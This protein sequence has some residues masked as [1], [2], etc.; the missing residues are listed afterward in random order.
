MLTALALGLVLSL[1]ILQNTPSFKTAVSKH[2]LTFLEHE[3][4]TRI[5]VETVKLNFFTFSIYF[6]NGSLTSG[7]H[8]NYVWGFE[9]AKIHVSPL[10]LLFD[11]EI[12]LDLSFNN[13]KGQSA[14]SNNRIDI[15]DHI[16]DIFTQRSPDLKISVSSL[17]LNN[18]DLDL[19]RDKELYALHVPGSL[20]LQRAQT[21]KKDIYHWTGALDLVDAQI[22]RND[23]I[24]AQKITGPIALDKDIET[25]IWSFKPRVE[26]TS[27]PLNPNITYTLHG[28]WGASQHS[29]ELHDTS[30]QILLTST[31]VANNSVG[32]KGTVPVSF[33]HNIASQ[34]Q[35]QNAST[36]GTCDLNLMLTHSND[37]ITTTGSLF[38][39]D[40]KFGTFTLKNLGFNFN[41]QPDPTSLA[42]I[43]GSCVWDLKQA[44]GTLHLANIFPV[45]PKINDDIPAQFVLQPNDLDLSLTLDSAG[46]LGGIYRCTITNPTTEKRLSYKGALLLGKKTFGINGSTSRGKYALHASLDPHFHL[47]SWHYTVGDKDLIN[48]YHDKQNP[49]ILQGTCEWSLLRS[50]LNQSTRRLIFGSECSFA[51]TLDQSSNTLKQGT[52]KLQHGTLYIPEFHNLVHTLKTDF[53]LDLA[54]QKFDLSNLKLELSKGSATCPHATMSWNDDYTLQ[55][56][57][58]PLQINDM[59]INWKRDFYGSVYGNLL[60]N[61]LPDHDTLL[62][63]VLILK[64]ALL[65]DSFFNSAQS[66]TF[67]SPL[68]G[69]I[70]RYPFPCDLHVKLM[71]EKPIRAKTASIDAEASLNLTVMATHGKDY[72]TFPYLIGDITLEN[73]KVKIL[74]NKLTIDHGKIQFI[75]NRMHDPIIDLSAKNRINKY[76]VNL[77]VSGSLEKPSI[78]LESTPDLTEEQIIGLLLSGSEN[79]TL[80][81]DLPAMLL[82]NLDSL[83]W[84]NKKQTRTAA[85]FDTLSKTFKY[86]QITPNLNDSSGKSLMKGSLSLNVSDQLHAQIH[87]NL[88]TQHNDFSAQLEYYLTDN[89]NIKVVQDQRDKRGESGAEIEVCLKL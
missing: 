41:E 55:L 32:I 61:K 45:A 58:I 35:D 76:V 82:Q 19:T 6:G 42:Q 89:V 48:F 72:G 49:L 46:K 12:C 75:K 79:S 7:D 47:T 86:V 30:K 4:K 71:T 69:G 62:A 33:L 10:K 25:E 36:Q 70:T 20:V 67:G 80:Q 37:A 8:K 77:T 87:K 63:G 38:F 43:T 14:F 66:N 60:L 5:A 29:L 52:I 56:I 13:L 11:K 44:K 24:L 17:M 64:K 26:F 15:V 50:F 68:Q 88:T 28:T 84:S 81:A 31:Q 1:W 27:P 78:M 40:L 3:W 83:L 57:H 59:F 51:L 34:Q 85:M 23:Q 73:G 16:F 22:K 21:D 54:A 74:N 9:Q 65:K 53:T 39:K 18:I 2:L